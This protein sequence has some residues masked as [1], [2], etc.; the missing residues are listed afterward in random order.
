M[1]H[2]EALRK[3][4]SCLRLAERAGTPDEAAVAAAKAQKIIDDY[5]LDISN[6]EF[7]AE[8][9]KEDKEEVKDFGYADPLDDVKYGNY[10]ESWT[11]R[12]ASLVADHN[13]CKIRY[14]KKADKGILLRVIGRPSDAQVVRYLY[15]FFRIQ[16][17]ELAAKETK[18]NSSTYRGEFCVGCIDTLSQKMRE[19]RQATVAEVKAKYSGDSM[20]LV[21][22]NSAIARITK[23][24]NDVDAFLKQQNAELVSKWTGI[25]VGIVSLYLDFR[26]D[27]CKQACKEANLKWG[28]VQKSIKSCFRGRGGFGGAGSKAPSG[29]RAHGQ[30]SGQSIRMTGAKAGIGAGRKGIE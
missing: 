21:K 9:L 10:R 12:L 28:D 26:M 15:S 1:T 16:I 13:Q 23:R 4:M 29:G 11:L 2:E 30:R 14:Q 25:P 27:A 8:Q 17:D 22:V 6:L 3:A 5:K 20:S 19:Q 7:D 18:G 24:A